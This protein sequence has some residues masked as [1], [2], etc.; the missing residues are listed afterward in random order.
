MLIAKVYAE[1]WE[2]DQRL[3]PF[4]VTRAEILRIIPLIVAAKAD[5]VDD[6]PASA[7]GQF[8][9]IYGTRYLRGLFRS[10]KYKSHRERGIE[11]VRHPDRDLKIVY[12]SVDLAGVK[13]HSPR[14][15][16]GKGSGAGHLIDQGMLFS[17][18]ELEKLNP[19]T[20]KPVD[21]GTWFLCVSIEDEIVGVELSLPSNIEG[22]NFG[23]FIER[24]FI[25]EPGAGAKLIADSDDGDDAAEFEPT[26]SRK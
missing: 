19:S 9:Y 8:A 17:E 6:D 14:A 26:V 12:Q 20:I 4:G 21:T 11:A 1:E 25:V 3:A 13:G 7:A 5:A 18:K 15:I 10:K 16:S 23:A 2:I 24:I 22:D